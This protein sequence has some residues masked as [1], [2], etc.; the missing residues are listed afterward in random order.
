[1]FL[2]PRKRKLSTTS[3]AAAVEDVNID[4]GC[5]VSSRAPYDD[6]TRFDRASNSAAGPRQSAP[7][8]WSR[9]LYMNTA[10]K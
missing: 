10:I 2:D 8:S 9:P 5:G 7:T 3:V 6:D 4:G 1:M